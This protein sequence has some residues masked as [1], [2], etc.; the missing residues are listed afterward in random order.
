MPDKILYVSHLEATMRVQPRLKRSRHEAVW[1]RLRASRGVLPLWLS[2]RRPSAAKE[3]DSGGFLDSFSK[4]ASGVQNIAVVVGLVIGG[5]WALK[6]F[7]FQNPAFYESGGEVA[8]REPEVIR[9]QLSVET[10]DAHT[11]SYEIV[12]SVHNANKTLS[13]IVQPSEIEVFFFEQGEIKQG[14]ARFSSTQQVSSGVRIPTQESREFRFF[15]SFP[16]DGVYI[17]ESNVCAKHSHNCLAQRYVYARG[18]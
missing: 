14:R 11:R 1:V 12:L 10:L 16:R 2:H 17:V 7:V 18:G 5:W 13:Q 8:G 15:V 3:N 4:F 6:T 9:A